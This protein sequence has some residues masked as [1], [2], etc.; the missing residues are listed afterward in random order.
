MFQ[1]RDRKRNTILVHPNLKTPRHLC[2]INITTANLDT[3]YSFLFPRSK[4]SIRRAP[5]LSKIQQQWKI[6]NHLI[7]NFMNKQELEDISMSSVVE[8]WGGWGGGTLCWNGVLGGHFL[9]IKMQYWN[10]C[11]S[12]LLQDFVS[13]WSTLST[14]SQRDAWKKLKLPKI[15]KECHKLSFFLWFTHW[16]NHLCET[17]WL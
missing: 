6:G 5:C 10:K 1:K 8:V 14:L 12:S 4:Y 9:G 7:E 2:Y 17:N 11:L 3:Y 13:F 16:W 15:G